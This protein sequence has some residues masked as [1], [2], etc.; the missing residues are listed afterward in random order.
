MAVA[1]RVRNAMKKHGGHEYNIGTAA[2]M[3]GDI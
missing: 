1:Q 2:D 3:L